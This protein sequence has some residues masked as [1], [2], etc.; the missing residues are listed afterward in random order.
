MAQIKQAKN[1]NYSSKLK[2]K[3]M[4]RIR[5]ME[6]IEAYFLKK[7]NLR[8]PDEREAI[9]RRCAAGRVADT[10]H[11]AGFRKKEERDAMSR[12]LRLLVPEWPDNPRRAGELVGLDNIRLKKGHPLRNYA[13]F[14][15]SV[16]YHWGN[17][18]KG[19]L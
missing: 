13:K 10:H 2:V 15:H 18:T 3:I 19:G 14:I 6:E 7:F 8:P 5:S 12:S 9:C 16:L 1:I 11:K 4:K 17:L